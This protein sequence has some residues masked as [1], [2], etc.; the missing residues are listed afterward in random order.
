VV[1]GDPAP[2]ALL[3]LK[4]NAIEAAAALGAMSQREAAARC[5]A[6]R[7]EHENVTRQHVEPDEASI[8]ANA[9]RLRA[10]LIFAATDHCVTRCAVRWV[11][12]AVR[13]RRMVR[14]ATYMRSSRVAITHSSNGWRSATLPI[15][16]YLRW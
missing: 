16:E 9:E 8:L 11:R 3:A 1:T 15:K 6:L 2:D 12:Y 10:A 4:I 13:R 5:A 14:L 7:A